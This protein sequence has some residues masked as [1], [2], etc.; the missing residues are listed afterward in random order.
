MAG[1]GS[2][3]SDRETQLQSPVSDE[4]RKIFM[5]DSGDDDVS[6]NSQDMSSRCCVTDNGEDQIFDIS[7][8]KRIRSR[9]GERGVLTFCAGY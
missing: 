2:G 9:R 1:V 4:R 7:S 3:T 6:G 8:S 5:A